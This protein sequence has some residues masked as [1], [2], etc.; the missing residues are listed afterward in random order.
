MDDEILVFNPTATSRLKMT[1]VRLNRSDLNGLTLGIIDNGKPN[2]D[3]LAGHMAKILQEEYGV[4][5]VVYKSKASSA[6]PAPAAVYDE[7]A[8]QCDLVV[9]GSGD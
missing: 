5:N 3:V 9:T 4:A 6:V 7:L 2:F 1:G 8:A